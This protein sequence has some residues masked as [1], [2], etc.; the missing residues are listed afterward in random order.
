[1]RYL[2]V[3]PPVSLSVRLSLYSVETIN[4]ILK[5]FTPSGSHTM[6]VF[7]CHTKRYGNIPTGTFL[8]GALNAGRVGKNRDSRPLSGFETDYW[9]RFS[10]SGGRPFFMQTVTHQRISL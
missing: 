6:L 2:S 3:R 8:T 4:H 5:L 10:Y 9:C 1:M 7:L